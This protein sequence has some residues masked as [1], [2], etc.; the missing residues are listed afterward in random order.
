M[1][2]ILINV[3]IAISTKASR[4]LLLII[5]IMP[6]RQFFTS[7]LIIILMR[8]HYSLLDNKTALHRINAQLNLH[9]P[10]HNTVH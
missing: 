2:T 4:L 3:D 5:M 6:H 7:S 10:M 8:S 9:F 1:N